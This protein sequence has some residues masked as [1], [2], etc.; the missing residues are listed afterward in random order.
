MKRF[1]A[2]TVVW[3]LADTRVRRVR[4][5]S[6]DRASNTYLVQPLR[7]R[8]THPR[9]D[10]IRVRARSLFGTP[11]EASTAARGLRLQLGRAA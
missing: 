7:L 8:P 2:E 6:Y 9:P 4:V 1:L 3:H 10:T 5:V 11:G